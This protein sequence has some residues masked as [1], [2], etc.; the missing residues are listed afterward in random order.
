MSSCS[1]DK[2]EGELQ[3]NKSDRRRCPQVLQ[4]LT[5]RIF[6]HQCGHP[7]AHLEARPMGD[8][9]ESLQD[10]DEKGRMIVG[11]QD[12]MSLTSAGTR[13]WRVE[14]KWRDVVKC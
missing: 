4:E 2:V 5:A 3:R 12:S 14:A 9:G 11:Q 8:T 13:K 7:A 10:E 6:R 1:E